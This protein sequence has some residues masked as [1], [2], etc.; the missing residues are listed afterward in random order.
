MAVSA[1]NQEYESQ[2]VIFDKIYDITDFAKV[3]PGGRV[4]K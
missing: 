2:L 4:I 3:H 1:E